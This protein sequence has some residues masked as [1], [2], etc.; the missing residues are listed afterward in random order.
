LRVT[1]AGVVQE[2]VRFVVDRNRCGAGRGIDARRHT[3]VAEARVLG[4]DAQD[5][6][7]RVLGRA[8]RG[9]SGSAGELDSC[10]PAIA[11]KRKAR[12]FEMDVRSSW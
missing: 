12:T 1:L 10:S 5:V 2:R 9:G 6:R 8:P 4:L 3:V 7:D 11:L